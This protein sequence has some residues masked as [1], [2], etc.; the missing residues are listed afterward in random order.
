MIV[1]ANQ[2]VKE[3][4]EN[5]HSHTFL[6]EECDTCHAYSNLFLWF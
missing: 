6:I 5:A 3:I 4:M 2:Y 1:K